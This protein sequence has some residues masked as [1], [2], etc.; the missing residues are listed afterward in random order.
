MMIDLDISNTSCCG[1]DEL[2]GIAEEQPENILEALVQHVYHPARPEYR[3]DY[4]TSKQVETGRTIPEK[5]T[6]NAFYLFT[7]ATNDEE[8]LDDPYGDRLKAFIEGHNLGTVAMTES[9]VNPNSGNEVTVYVWAVDQTA[10]RKF[11]KQTFLGGK[12]DGK[13][14]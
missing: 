8:G 14:K 12:V 5:W 11:A 9:R 4:K 2:H 13:R 6:T 7:Q 3:Y 10:F 1:L